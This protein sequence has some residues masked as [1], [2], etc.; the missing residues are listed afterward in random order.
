MQEHDV[1]LASY[2]AT[3]A[4]QLGQQLEHLTPVVARAYASLCL[5]SAA[6]MRQ[7]EALRF[8]DLALSSCKVQ[9]EYS[10][11]AYYSYCSYY[12]YYSSGSNAVTQ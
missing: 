9:G 4:L 10:Y 1:P 3:R 8:K 7:R 2:C 12:A 5:T 6:D 11:Y